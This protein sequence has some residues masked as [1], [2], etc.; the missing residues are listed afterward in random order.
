MTNLNFI[1]S[2]LTLAFSIMLLLIIGV[3]KKKSSSLIYNLSILTLLIIFILSVLAILTF[4]P[5][6]TQD[7]LKKI[8]NH[9][10]YRELIEGPNLLGKSIEET[11]SLLSQLDLKINELPVSVYNP[12]F[13]IGSIV[14]QDPKPGNF[15]K[16]GRTI[17]VTPNP[18][19]VTQIAI[20]NYYD[21]SFRER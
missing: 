20:P 18:D 1:Y 15:V 13:P 4:A 19:N 10:D 9:P 16:N 5:S 21:K 7:K 8:T 3:F 17:Y 14:R 11:K 2:E 6:F 12:N